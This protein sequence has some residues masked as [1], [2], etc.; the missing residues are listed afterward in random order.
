ML[1]EKE[2]EKVAGPRTGPEG[3]AEFTRIGAMKGMGLCGGGSM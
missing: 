1:L 3:E 2:E